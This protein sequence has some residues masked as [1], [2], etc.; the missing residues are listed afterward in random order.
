MA[1]YDEKVEKELK[2]WKYQPNMLQFYDNVTY[3]LRWYLIPHDINDFIIENHR[4]GN[5][6]IY[7]PDNYKVII[8]ETGVSTQYSI[9]SLTI[10]NAYGV[11]GYDNSINIS[12]DMDIMEIN[13]CSLNNKIAA[14]SKLLGYDNQ[15]CQPY[16]IDIWF[17]GYEPPK[18]NPIN[19]IG[20]I[21]TY[22]AVMTTAD[23]DVTDSG[24]RHNLKFVGTSMGVISKDISLLNNIAPV[25]A[26]TVEDFRKNLEEQINHQYFDL[27]PEL[28]KYFP[29]GDFLTINLY[30]SEEFLEDTTMYQETQTMMTDERD[31]IG[32]YGYE[33]AQENT[34]NG[35]LIN[36]GKLYSMTSDGTYVPYA[37]AIPTQNQTAEKER[38]YTPYNN[39]NNCV[40][41]KVGENIDTANKGQ[42]VMKMDNNQ[43]LENVFQEV[44]S[45]SP[46]LRDRVAKVIFNA[47]PIANKEGREIY[48]LT[49]NVFFKRDYY[50]KWFIETSKNFN[51]NKNVQVSTDVYDAYDKTIQEMQLSA[52]QDMKIAKTLN[53]RYDY[54]FNGHDTSVLELSTKIDKLWYMNSSQNYLADA[55]ENTPEIIPQYERARRVAELIEFKKQENSTLSDQQAFQ[56]VLKEEETYKNLQDIRQMATDK[57]LYL[58][59][60]YMCLSLKQKGTLL[61]T[62]PITPSN[63]PWGQATVATKTGSIDYNCAKAGFANLHSTGNL[64]NIKFKILGDPYWLDMF[65][66]K[67][68]NGD[69]KTLMNLSNA[70]YF[71]FNMKTAVEQNSNGNGLYD[72]ESVYDISGLYQVLYVTNYFENGKFTQDIEG[73]IHPAFIHSNYLKV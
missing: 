50:I 60:I 69:L 11:I 1:F 65:S 48:K 29:S 63:D 55:V 25:K 30:G 2:A 71:A 32:S 31:F 9:D 73:S 28:R 47:K 10:K 34:K 19:Q 51:F 4:N 33:W 20:G 57:R 62:R 61:G 45:L 16:F 52:L 7:I 54:L 15:L 58:D 35:S 6:N 27:H 17:T 8:A 38:N 26:V 22:S 67:N 37:S 24:T 40:F 42:L 39:F 43:I 13:G 59:D 72:M 64:I 23:T 56:Q 44:C 3:N 53:K 68:I 12:I 18:N 21:I 36:Q 49:M 46:Q 70:K 5:S 66:E 41:D 14:I